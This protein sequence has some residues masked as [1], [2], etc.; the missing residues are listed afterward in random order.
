LNISHASRLYNNSP[1]IN[2]IVNNVPSKV[3]IGEFGQN[4]NTFDKE[5]LL[6]QLLSLLVII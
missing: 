6:K 2:K 1:K 5:A 3:R 4:I